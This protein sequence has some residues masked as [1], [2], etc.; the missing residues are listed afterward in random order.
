MRQVHSCRSTALSRR[1]DGTGVLRKGRFK[2]EGECLWLD[3]RPKAW[4][5]L[6]A[7]L[8]EPEALR[9][10]LEPDGVGHTHTGPHR[11]RRGQEECMDG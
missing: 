3:W 6:D 7:D 8:G 10:P 5:C 4:P 11:K 9:F 1:L 2:E